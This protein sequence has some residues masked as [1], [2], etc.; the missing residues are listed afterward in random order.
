MSNSKNN[1][2]DLTKIIHSGR[3]PT[4]HFGSVNPPIIQSSTVIFPT[5]ADYNAAED[6]KGY[7]E[8][9]FDISTT[10]PSYGIAGSQ[11]TAAL[12]KVLTELENGDYTVITNSG[13]SAINLVFLAFLQAGDHL[14]ITDSLYGPVRR[15]CNKTLKKFGVEITYYN[16]RS[17]ADDLANLIKPNTKMIYLESPGTMTF[18]I[19]DIEPI[20]A[21][22]KSKNIITAIDNSWG[23]PLYFKPLNFGVDIS[24]NALTKFV[25]GHSDVLLGAVITNAA[26]TDKIRKE[27]KNLGLSASAHDCYLALRG[28]RTIG[29]RMEYQ[30]NS[31]AKVIEY[32]KTVPQVKQILFPAVASSPDYAL[33]K[34]YF[35]GCASLFSVVLDK[36]YTPD[37]LGKMVDGYNL[38]GIGASWGGFESLVKDFEVASSRAHNTFNLEGNS[39]LRYYIG[40]ENPDDIIADLKQGFARLS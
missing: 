9:L 34:K 24:I 27:Y 39:A 36:K 40:L 19:Q 38:F 30:Q 32:L 11:T 29:V 1:T 17:T 22:A 31:V 6:G 3:N 20:V 28:I 8:D 10:D 16:A 5:L 25:S 33:Y 15:F 2:S 35:T 12:Q 26:T 13:L 37:Q 23:G 4:K 21:L 14:L 18:E 7:Y